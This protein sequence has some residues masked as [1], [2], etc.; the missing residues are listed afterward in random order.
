[1]N[2]CFVHLLVPERTY[3]NGVLLHRQQFKVLSHQT[4]EASF[5]LHVVQGLKA[6]CSQLAKS[7]LSQGT[8]RNH[9]FLD[10]KKINKIKKFRSNEGRRLASYLLSSY[11]HLSTSIWE[12]SWS[13]FPFY[14]EKCLKGKSVYE[15]T[16]TQPLKRK[17]N[18]SA[19]TLSP[20]ILKQ[21]NP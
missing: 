16:E 17:H 18:F 4:Q 12:Y 11:Y 1:M 2:A 19:W 3:V 8:T 13:L 5:H 9:P 6:N 7:H 20:L 15:D 21:K 14:L 10:E